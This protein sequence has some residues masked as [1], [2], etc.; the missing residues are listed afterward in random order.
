[1]REVRRFRDRSSS[2]SRLAPCVASV[3]LV[4]WSVKRL[5]RLSGLSWP[6]KERE[7][8]RGHLAWKEG[9]EE[10]EEEEEEEEGKEERRKKNE[11][12]RTGGKEKN[13]FFFLFSGGPLRSY[14]LSLPPT[15]THTLNSHVVCVVVV[16]V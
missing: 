15:H 9:K 16:V 12:M 8:E 14:S 13:F 6:A 7:R 5:A 10:R 1:M 11:Q 4:C 3:G 2:S